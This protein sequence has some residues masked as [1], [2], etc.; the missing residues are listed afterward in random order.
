MLP[1]TRHAPAP[2][3][4]LAAGSFHSG[5]PLLRM[6]LP[7]LPHPAM[8]EHDVSIAAFDNVLDTLG[9]SRPFPSAGTLIDS[10]NVPCVPRRPL[11]IELI[12]QER[13]D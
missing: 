1:Q 12:K 9:L 8:Y 2:A 4:L 3:A 5:V 6:H 10:A 11:R 13:L 7:S